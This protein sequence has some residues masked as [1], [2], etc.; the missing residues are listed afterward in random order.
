MFVD[1]THFVGMHLFWWLFWVVAFVTFFSVMTPMPRQRAK[2]LNETPR[3]TILR[4]FAH[5]EIDEQE[6]ERRKIIV[7]RD[8]RHDSELKQRGAVGSVGKP[9]ST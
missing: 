9:L 8:V 1:S 4:R 2:R 3:D 6:Y 7:D 5:G